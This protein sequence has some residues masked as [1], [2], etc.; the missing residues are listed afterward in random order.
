MDIKKWQYTD[1]VFWYWHLE[2]AVC[3]NST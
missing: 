1:V 3:K 2:N